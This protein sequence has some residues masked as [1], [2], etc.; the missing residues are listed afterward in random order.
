MDPR[1]RG[2]E[3]PVRKEEVVKEHM[4]HHSECGHPQHPTPSI[5]ESS[6]W[7]F[8]PA[9]GP[10]FPVCFLS[11]K[12]LNL[13]HTCIPPTPALSPPW[14]PSKPNITSHLLMITSIYFSELL[15]PQS[16]RTGLCPS[17]PT[18]LNRPATFW[19]SFALDTLPDTMLH[20]VESCPSHTLFPFPDCQ[21]TLLSSTSSP[22]SL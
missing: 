22:K 9:F 4:E 10:P 16:L 8:R 17:S 15:F 3:S 14:P 11:P 20:Q 18:C 5:K 2:R 13:L 1:G 6:L 21:N 12:C 19:L 7:E